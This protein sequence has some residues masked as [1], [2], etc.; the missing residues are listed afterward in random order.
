LLILLSFEG[1]VSFFLFYIMA[2]IGSQGSDEV[3]LTK[4]LH[5]V[6]LNLHQNPYPYVSNP[7]KCKKRA[8][9]TLIL[10]IRPE[11]GYWPESP[12][13]Q[14]DKSVSTIQQLKNFFSQE[15]V[16]HGDPEV[17]FIKRASRVGDRWTGH[18]A[19]PGGKRDPEDADDV[20][21]AVRET[22]EETGLDLT[23]ENYV[24]VG[25]LPERVVT[26]SWDSVPYVGYGH[27]SPKTTN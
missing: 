10:R 17:L 14:L 16:Q 5:D 21:T 6:L 25:N 26:T 15:W 22:W 2:T 23:A 12:L 9:V 8:A 13:P 7:P 18:V 11:Y 24:H 27:F 1:P 19:L 4:A 3:S 20:A